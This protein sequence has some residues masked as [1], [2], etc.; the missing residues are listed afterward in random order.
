[1]TDAVFPEHPIPRDTV[2]IDTFWKVFALEIYV[3]MY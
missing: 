1:M 3:N 2:T